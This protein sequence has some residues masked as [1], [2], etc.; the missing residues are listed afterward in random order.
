MIRDERLAN[1]N[2]YINTRGEVIEGCREMY[3]EAFPTGRQ[4][5]SQRYIPIYMFDNGHWTP[6]EPR[7]AKSK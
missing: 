7:I 3:L 5:G 2:V 6:N 4:D 1:D